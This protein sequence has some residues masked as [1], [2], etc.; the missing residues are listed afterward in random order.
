[1]QKWFNHIH[2]HIYKLIFSLHLNNPYVTHVLL[3][4]GHPAVGNDNIHI[5]LIC[6]TTPK[7]NLPCSVKS[8]NRYHI[9]IEECRMEG[10]SQVSDEYQ[11]HSLLSQAII[12]YFPFIKLI[13]LSLKPSWLHNGTI[14]V[15]KCLKRK[16]FYR[17]K[18]RWIWFP[19]VQKAEHLR[20]NEYNLI[21]PSFGKRY[22]TIHSILNN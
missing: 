5:V 4:D 13:K 15:L 21:Q 1:M 19:I 14:S 18:E 10:I 20:A 7:W 2:T 9:D 3:Q 17:F 11:I 6:L 22:V 16:C 12:S 8:V